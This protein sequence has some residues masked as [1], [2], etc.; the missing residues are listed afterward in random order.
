MTPGIREPELW[1][2]NKVS[3]RNHVYVKCICRI[4]PYYRYRHLYCW[5]IAMVYTKIFGHLLLF[6]RITR[7]LPFSAFNCLLLPFIAFFKKGKS[8]KNGFAFFPSLL[9]LVLF[10]DV[11]KWGRVTYLPTNLMNCWLINT[12]IYITYT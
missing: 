5:D 1:C 4:T 8:K 6:G 3:G 10:S 7:V 11:A 12:L 2:Y 9:V